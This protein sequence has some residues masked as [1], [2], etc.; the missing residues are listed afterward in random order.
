MSLLLHLQRCLKLFVLPY[1][2]TN[3]RQENSREPIRLFGRGFVTIASQGK[4]RGMLICALLSE[5]T[6]RMRVASCEY[7]QSKKASET[8]FPAALSQSV[9]LGFFDD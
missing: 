7:S 2:Q 8:P 6:S 3:Y 1:A 4:G 9:A 5:S